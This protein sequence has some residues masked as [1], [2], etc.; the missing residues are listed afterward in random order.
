MGGAQSKSNSLDVT[1]A[2][3]AE[4]ANKTVFNLD[5]IQKLY[6][7]YKIYSN[8]DTQDNKYDI[9][10]FMR[11]LAMEPT[12]MC[13]RIFNAFDSDTSNQIDFYEFIWGLS[14]LS[15]RA[16]ISEK[17]G[18]V[19]AIYDIDKNGSISAS[20]FEDVMKLSFEGKMPEEEI[21]QKADQYF[22]EMDSSNT[23]SATM[24]DFNK[25]VY[26]HPEILQCANLDVDKLI[27]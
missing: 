15:T 4:L 2:D 13:V 11:F 10:E 23:G 21:K 25:A 9:K 22:A 12:P 6:N 14:A 3:M 7:R 19:F 27:N 1:E 5:E 16:S 8:S 20:E 17:A 26:K 18:F 24:T